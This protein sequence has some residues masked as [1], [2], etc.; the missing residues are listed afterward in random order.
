M[1]IWNNIVFER[2]FY[3]LGVIYEVRTLRCCKSIPPPPCTCTYLFSLH[4]LPVS[5]NLRILSFKEDMADMFC[6]LLSIKEPQTTFKMKNLLYKAIGNCRITIPRR[7]LGSSLCFL[8]VQRRW[9]W[10]VL[11]V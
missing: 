10:I 11:A 6:E 3:P 8:T 9:E 4:P 2:N 1:T 7:T 5:T